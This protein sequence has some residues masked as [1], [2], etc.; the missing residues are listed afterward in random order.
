MV[1]K[2]NAKH[3]WNALKAKKKNG[4]HENKYKQ[5]VRKNRREETEK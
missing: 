5:T 3:K 2:Q 1:V 4:T